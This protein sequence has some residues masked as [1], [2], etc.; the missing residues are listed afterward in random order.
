MRKTAIF[1]GLSLSAFSLFAGGPPV[2]PLSVCVDV[3]DAV[4]MAPEQVQRLLERHDSGR[5]GTVSA[6]A[7]TENRTARAFIIPSAGSVQ[8]AGG[9]FFR[10]DVSL[11]NCAA[12]AQD[13]AVLWLEIGSSKAVPDAVKITLPPDG[14]VVT[15]RDFV[16]TQ[17]KRSGLGSLDLIPLAGGDGAVD[18]FSRIWTNQ[19]GA[20][21]TVSLPFPGVDADSFPAQKQVVALGLRQDAAF[22]TNFGIVNAARESHTY[23]VTF[24]GQRLTTTSTVTVP[25]PGMI[26]ASIPAGDYGDLVI[27]FEIDD[28]QASYIGYA[29]STDNISGDG[30]VSIGSGRFDPSQLDTIGK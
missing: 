26:Q 9:T 12:Q 21:G 25:G 15:Y 30:W 17:L 3:P 10:S 24:A 22:R 19:P 6:S 11:V 13:V 8:G 28:D 29:S 14:V 18:G 27:T 1:I 2:R 7:V 4:P 23:K 20:S 5:A 16:G